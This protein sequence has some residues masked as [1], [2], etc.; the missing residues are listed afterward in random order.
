MSTQAL[1]APALPAVA[2]PRG[3]VIL[4]GPQGKRETLASVMAAH[5]IDGRLA[6]VTA[7]WQ[8]R[9]DEIQALQAHLD[10][11]SDSLRLHQRADEV[12]RED[13]ELEAAHRERQ[14]L[15]RD[16]QRFYNVRITHAMA[17]VAELGR[18]PAKSVLLEEERE[19]ALG[20]VRKIDREHVERI[21]RIH[22]DFAPRLRLHERP[23]VERHRREIT[24]ILDG[25]GALGI[26]GGH[27][28]V[29]LN[30]LRL[31]GVVELAG[32]R[33][34][35]A[36]S[37]GAMVVTERIVLYHD[38]PP[39]GPGNPEVLDTGLALVRGLV[40]LPHARQRLRLGDADRV[41]R[42]ARRFAPASCVAMDE[43]ARLTIGPEG[44]TASE[45]VRVLGADGQLRRWEEV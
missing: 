30:R 13:P 19:A 14:S 37:G 10:G 45:E 2:D 43:G 6:T 23:A 38:S 42:F 44:C 39:Q 16:L 40:P 28:A 33:P 22:E 31:F 41:G 32:D 21:R 7:G 11:R 26:A 3:T 34:V 1:P 29:L 25:C 35:V 20:T 4:L 17:A 36:W 15:L 9:E 8:E 27:V 12:F 18:R 24:E 5:G